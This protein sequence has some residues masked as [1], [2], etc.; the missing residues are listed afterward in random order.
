MDGRACQ[1]VQKSG[2]DIMTFNFANFEDYHSMNSAKFM[3]QPRLP[4]PSIFPHDC[5]RVFDP[6]DVML[7]IDAL[8]RCVEIAVGLC[9]AS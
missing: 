3:E 8:V 1:S 6:L 2:E 5:G 9:K 7:Q 4:H